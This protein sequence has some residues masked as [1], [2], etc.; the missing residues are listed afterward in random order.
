MK[1]SKTT[2]DHFIEMAV[3]YQKELANTPWYRFRTR[4]ELRAWKE[5]AL[6]LAMKFSKK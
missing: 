4:R 2:E 6:E 3:K 1:N 5:S